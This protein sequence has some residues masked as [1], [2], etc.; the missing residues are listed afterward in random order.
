MNL[1]FCVIAW[2]SS[3]C[4]DRGELNIGID[5]PEDSAS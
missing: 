2:P 3:T 4:V 1:H 5:G